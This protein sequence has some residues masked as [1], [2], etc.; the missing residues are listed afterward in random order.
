MGGGTQ[1]STAKQEPWEE[2]I[3]YLTAGF[4]QAKGLYNKGAPAY[5]GK[6]TLAGFDPAQ[7]AAHTSA[8]R[9]TMGPRAAAQ[10]AHAEN[11][12]LKGLSGQIDT[13]SFNPMMDALG[14]QMTS[15]LQGK[16][17]PGIRQS[18]VEYQPGGGS[19]G[20]IVQA[21]AIASANQQMLNK[22]AEMTFGAQQAA[23]GRAQN[24]AQLYPSI[25]SAPL[26]NYAA[27]GEIGDARRAMTQ[28]TINR[29]MARH[30]YQSTAPQQALENYMRMIQGSY[31]GTTTQTTPGPSG[32]QTLGQI[33]S[34]AAPIMAL[35]D[36]RI[37]ENIEFDG[38][39]HGHNVYTYNF[40]GRTNRSRGVMAQEIEITRPDA[41][42]E[43]EGIK[44]VNYGVL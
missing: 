15:Q 7:T 35:S 39:W 1:V 26:G 42:M 32:L 33:A 29:D 34:I 27:M 11:R 16:V 21:N 10:Q 8:L 5:Y 19:R 23:Q 2:Q 28:E 24:Y 43:I 20:D 37:K 14:R 36:I 9:Y 13:A 17:L 4:E 31:G 18:M 22:A 44:H 25:M 30:Q 40:K 38:T 12:L 3:P 6:E 41:V